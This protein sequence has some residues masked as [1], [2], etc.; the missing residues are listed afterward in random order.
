MKNQVIKRKMGDFDVFQRTEDSMFNATELMRQW[1]TANKGNKKLA[2]FM[3]ND[4]TKEY[5]K[6][7]IEELSQ[8]RNSDNGDNQSVTL[9][10]EIK[11]RNTKN[12]RTPDTV[13]MH[14]LLFMEFAGYFS[15]RFRVKVNQFVLDHLIEYR[16]RIGDRYQAFSAAGAKVGCKTQEDFKNL[17]RCLNCAVLGKERQK[18]QR[19]ELSEV[20]ARELD[21]MQERFIFLVKDDYITDMSGMRKFFKRQYEKKFLDNMPFAETDE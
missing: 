1:N 4:S 20:E 16:N 9:L 12:G 8:S 14:P 10:K 18:E 17:A 7:V 11:G 5:I 21:E 3:E 2:Y 15:P 6:A 19:N 13:W